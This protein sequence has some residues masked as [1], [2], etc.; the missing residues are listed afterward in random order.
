[1]LIPDALKKQLSFIKKNYPANLN[2]RRIANLSLNIAESLLQFRR[3]RSL[4]LQIDLIPTR[5]CNLACRFCKNHTTSGSKQ[6]SLSDVEKIAPQLFPTALWLKICSGGE[7]YLHKDLEDILRIARRYNLMTFVLS[8]GMNMQEE[9]LRTIVR[10]GLITRHGFSVDGIQASTVERIRIKA[11]LPVILKNIDMLRRII[12]E[13]GANGPK[14]AIRYVLMRSTIDDLPDAI[15]YWGDRGIAYFDCSYLSLCN[16]IEKSESLYFHQDHMM[17]VFARARKIAGQYPHLELSLPLPTAS[18]V[19]FQ[20]HP[21]PCRLPWNFVA[22]DTDGSILPCY[23][24]FEAFNLG[25]PYCG[26]LSFKD[27]WNSKGYQELR[28]TV[29]SARGDKFYIYCSQ[30]ECRF[31]WSSLAAHFGDETWFSL[32]QKASLPGIAK[33]KHKRP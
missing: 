28:K 10:E 26:E 33:V 32:M 31:G 21:K 18:Q 15:R 12:Q 6:I 25:N 24:V 3:C 13:E 20:K 5:A 8:N 29:N 19:Q 17:D 7:P 30:C 4:P 16:D 23:C 27:V 11:Q 22:I 14:I 9:R 1:M 2:L